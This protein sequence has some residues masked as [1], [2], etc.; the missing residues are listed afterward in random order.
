MFIKSRQYDEAYKW[1]SENVGPAQ[2]W[3]SS[4]GWGWRL[5][6]IPL[7][8]ESEFEV[9]IDCSELKSLFALKFL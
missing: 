8:G 9:V 5:N 7:H 6:F 1:L 3:A 4:R 2:E